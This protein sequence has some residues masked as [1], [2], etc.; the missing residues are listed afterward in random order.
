MK[1]SQLSPEVITQVQ[2]TLWD[3]IFEKHEGPENW[4]DVLEYY[5]PEFLD[6]EGHAVLLPIGQEQHPN[7]TILRCIPSQ[8]G[9]T[10]TLFLKDT[11]YGD[12]TFTSGYLAVCDKMPGQEF[13]LAIV[14]HEWF[15]I[16]PHQL[17]RRKPAD[18]LALA[19]TLC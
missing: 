3:G 10:L 18:T 5:N 6:I 12:D 7:L 1:L 8:D 17:L 4:E 9:K 13:F 2:S 19:E 11:T 16:D 15:I 14:Y